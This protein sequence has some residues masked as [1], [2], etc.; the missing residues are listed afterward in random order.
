MDF[1]PVFFCGAVEDITGYTEEELRA[2][3]PKWNEIIHPDDIGFLSVNKQKIRSVSNYATECEYR[4]IRRDG[5]I[6]WVHERIKNLCNGSGKPALAQGT[7]CDV[8]DRKM[9]EDAL[10]KSEARYRAVV[11]DQNELI[12]RFRPD[13]T[14]T[15]VNAACSKFMGKKSEELKGTNLMRYI[16]QD[17]RERFAKYFASFDQSNPVPICEFRITAATGEIRWIRCTSRAV[18]D[19][20]GAITEFQ[21]VAR[22]I[23]ERKLTEEVLL[24][25]QKL[26]SLGIMAGGIA[27]DFNNLL[28][29]ILG[30]ITLAKTRRNLEP[31]VLKLLSEAEKAALM[32]EHLTQQLLT[33]AKGGSPLKK[34]V[35]IPKLLKEMGQFAARGSNVRCEFQ[36]AED[37]RPV[38]IDEGQIQQV[39]HNLVLNSLQSMPAGGNIEV[40]TENV[41]LDGTKFGLPASGNYVKISISDQGMGIPPDNLPK[42]FDPYF[43]TRESGRGLGLA[44]TYSIIEKHHGYVD[45]ESRVG[46]GTTFHVYLPAVEAQIVEEVEGT[47]GDELGGEGKILLMDDEQIVRHIAREMLIHLGY[48]VAIACNGAEAVDIYRQAKESGRS[49][50]AVIL[51]LTVPGGMGGQDTLKKLMEIDPQ[52]KGIVSSGYSHDSIMAEFKNY[53][54]KGVIAKPYSLQEFGQALRKILS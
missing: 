4:I 46:Q 1:T 37:T 43:S 29:G 33:F 31:D 16:V 22:D 41:V 9:A 30:N 25:A 20:Q 17:D 8:T 27:H 18:S 49:F 11:E 13:A 12:Y 45:V 52:V 7:I 21:C 3:K 38:E 23:T 40:R 36:L 32:A 48:E 51:D 19:S 54:F 24:R 6:R 34:I 28:T 39:I 50:D 2:G 42:V 35:S 14:L 5:H 53:G 26:Q 47:K 10:S 44:V 15:F